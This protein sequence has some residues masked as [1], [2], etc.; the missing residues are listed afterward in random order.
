MSDEGVGDGL[1]ADDVVAMLGLTALPDEGGM[2]ALTYRDANCGA[3]Y[4]LVRPGDFSAM[5]RLSGAE[6][7]HHY[8]GSAVDM[9]LL[10]PNG[11]IERPV[12]GDDLAAGDR[13]FCAVSAGTWMGA[14][15]R[16]AWALVGTTM[17]PAFEPSSFELGD[18]ERLAAEY[19]SASVEIGRLTR[20]V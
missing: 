10:L 13:P 15:T 14:S 1:G 2:Y 16:G 5:H 17:A 6:L 3:I 8:A 18:R 4:F 12:L 19:P 11:D 20:P 9:L 7:W